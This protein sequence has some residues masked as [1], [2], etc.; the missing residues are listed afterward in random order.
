MFCVLTL[1]MDKAFISSQDH[2]IAVEKMRPITI[3]DIN[4]PI[5]FIKNT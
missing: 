2:V 4:Q 5:I 3:F 1:V